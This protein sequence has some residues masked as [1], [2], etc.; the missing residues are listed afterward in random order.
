MNLKLLTLNAHSLHGDR[1]ERDKNMKALCDFLWKERPDMIAM[2]EVNQLADAPTADTDHTEGYYR[3]AT[4]VA[5]VP[6][7]KGNFAMDLAWNMAERGIPYHFTFLPMKR[8]YGIF[9]E[10]LAIFS[11]S[12][13][14]TS[15]GFYI[16][17]GEDYGDHNTRMALLAEIKDRDIMI[18][19]TH[20]SRYDNAPDPFYDQWKRLT[21]RLS[22][23]ERLF[24]MGDLNCPAEVRGEGYDRA[25]EAG[26]LDAY[27]VADERIGGSATADMGIDGWEDR[28]SSGRIDYIFLNFYPKA[29]K[30]TYTR[31][32]DGE[33]GE[34]VSDHF[35]VMVDFS[36][37]EDH[38]R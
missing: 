3:A 5:P 32:L 6:L 33:R 19:N 16:S 15:C 31:V 2:Q 20:T 10:G 22:N 37:L 34:R 1:G 9:D 13:I 14:R 18:C 26:F 28:K 4:C 7:K 11:L 8:G 35:G 30:I 36:G 12:P 21:A 38:L 25:C 17:R 23:S 27:R 29:K 24:I